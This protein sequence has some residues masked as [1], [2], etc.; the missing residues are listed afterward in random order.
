MSRNTNELVKLIVDNYNGVADQFCGDENPNDLINAAVC[1][2]F[3]KESITFKDLR[4][5]SKSE[6]FFDVV[7]EV[8]EK[9][10]LEGFVADPIVDSLVD[11]R[12]IALGDEQAFDIED[13]QEIIVS[14]ISS[15]NQK[16]DRQRLGVGQRIYV[17]TRPV[18]CSVYEEF[19]RVKSGVVDFNSLISRVQKAYNRDLRQRIWAAFEGMFSDLSSYTDIYYKSGSYDATSLLTICEHVAAEANSDVIIVGSRLALNQ[20]N[21]DAASARL[22]T[23]GKKDIYDIGYIGKFNGIP[24]MAIQQF[25]KLGT[26]NTFG[27][28]TNDLFILPTD[29]RKPIKYV[30]EGE[31]YTST[32]NP[33][34]HADLTAEYK[35]WT[36]YGIAAVG[37]SQLGK[38]SIA[39]G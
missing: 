31:F 1:D 15:G 35:F 20:I 36:N 11:S 26:A 6:E 5:R 12:N 14:E 3:G 17:P 29:G 21:M 23:E 33:E 9:T 4:K 38:Y 2:I 30:T 16:F 28:P 19:R 24:C 39:N 13:D 22:G 32:I 25:H 34:D 18:G 37:K 27:V 10:V 7:S 8:L